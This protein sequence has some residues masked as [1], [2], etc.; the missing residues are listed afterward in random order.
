MKWIACS[1]R[2]DWAET[3]LDVSARPGWCRDP[4]VPS[5]TD[6]VGFIGCAEDLDRAHL[7]RRLRSEGFDPLGVPVVLLMKLDRDRPTWPSPC[8]K[9]S[10]P[11]PLCS[12]ATPP[13]QIVE[14]SASRRRADNVTRPLGRNSDRI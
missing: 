11:R 2:I 13:T 8:P 9:T 1:D 4:E 6:Q 12:S 7:E 5:D 10:R 3:D 14:T